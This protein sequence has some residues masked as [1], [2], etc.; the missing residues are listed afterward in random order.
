MLNPV[1]WSMP[2]SLPV[3][4]GTQNLQ[5]NPIHF[6]LRNLLATREGVPEKPCYLFFLFIIVSNSY[7]H[8]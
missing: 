1:S 3:M 2:K 4:R 8:K 5:G 7:S 6:I